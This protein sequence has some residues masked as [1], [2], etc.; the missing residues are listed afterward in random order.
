MFHHGVGLNLKN[1]GKTMTSKIM[2]NSE[3]KQQHVVFIE[4]H[5]RTEMLYN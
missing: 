3:K 4:S 2:K 1:F 5:Q